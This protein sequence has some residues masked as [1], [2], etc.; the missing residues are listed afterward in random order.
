M[1]LIIRTFIYCLFCVSCSKTDI[2][3]TTYSFETDE[4]VTFM[5]QDDENIEYLTSADRIYEISQLIRVKPI[6][7]YTIEIANFAPFDFEDITITTTV[8]G[9]ETPIKLLQIDK[10]K[11][12]AVH[13]ISYPFTN[14]TSKFLNIDNKEVNLSQY[15]ETGISPNDVTFDF[16][17]EGEIFDKLKDLEKL[18]WTV[19]YHDFDPDNNPDN[20][21][22]EDMSALD[23][24]RYTGLMINLGVVFASDTFKDAFLKEHIV[25]NDGTTVL[26]LQEK[27]TIYQNLLNKPRFNC[28]RSVNVSGL[29]GGATFGVANHVL[30]DYITKET[31]FVTAHEI[32]HMIGYNHNSNMTY[33]H[34]ID[35][36]NTGFSTVTSRIMNVFF[37][38]DWYPVTLENYY[39]PTDF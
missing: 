18:K 8:A 19:K 30:R 23:V 37:E 7:N 29:G 35:D 33:P 32:G 20:N 13:V 24:R 2:E 34:K 22:A 28:G 4:N 12:H 15:R 9:I 1:K 3:L 6:D 11:A 36:K 39:T 21:W 17:G 16:T 14:G 10:I 31:G 26:T 5:F 27:E 25:G 38:N